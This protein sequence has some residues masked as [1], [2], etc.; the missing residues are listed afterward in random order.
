LANQ[1]TIVKNQ[2][3]IKKNQKAL[4]AILANQKEILRNQKAI[5]GAVKK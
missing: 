1:K 4:D 3:D 5:L 2:G